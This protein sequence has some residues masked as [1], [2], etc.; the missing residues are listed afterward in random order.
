MESALYSNEGE[1]GLLDLPA[2][3][4]TIYIQILPNSHL[5]SVFGSLEWFYI[6]WTDISPL[7]SITCVHLCHSSQPMGLVF[8]LAAPLSDIMPT[9]LHERDNL[10]S[11]TD[12]VKLRP[13]QE[14]YFI[15]MA[16]SCQQKLF[17]SRI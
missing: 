4:D 17:D 16:K 9:I 1:G 10:T 11:L 7:Q 12:Q 2:A 3:F 15:C 8:F 13:G 6:S 5:H 14:A